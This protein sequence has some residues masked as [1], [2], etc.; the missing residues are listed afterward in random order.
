MLSEPNSSCRHWVVLLCWWFEG[1]DRLSSVGPASA[2]RRAYR[3][4]LFAFVVCG[5]AAVCPPVIILIPSLCIKDDVSSRSVTPWPGP[6]TLRASRTIFPESVSGWWDF[7]LDFPQ[8]V[9]CIALLR[10]PESRESMYRCERRCSQ[11]R[12]GP[13]HGVGQ[14]GMRIPCHGSW[15]LGGK[16]AFQW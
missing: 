4:Y 15:C 14:K 16:R 13:W 6:R 3:I 8:R 12:L 5:E 9:H 10:D 1:D 11:A 2:C 7:S